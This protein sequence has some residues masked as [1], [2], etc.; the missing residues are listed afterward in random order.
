MSAA[1]TA[2][3]LDLIAYLLQH[4]FPVTRE[5]IFRHI[6]G[7]LDAPD[8]ASATE[9]ESARRQ[10]ERDKD[11]LRAL[12]IALETVD[13]PDAAGD[14]PAKG[15]RLPERG[16]YLPYI[17]LEPPGAAAAR[18][19]AGLRRIAV[20]P[21]E[22]RALD[23]AT[24]RVAELKVEPFSRAALS[25]RRKLEF[26]LPLNREVF[27]RALA[28]PLPDEGKNALEVVQRAVAERLA[29]TCEYYAIGRDERERREIEPCGL[30]FNWGRWYCVARAR[31]RDA[32]RVFRVDRM[33]NA[34]LQTGRGARFQLPAGFSIRGYVD[35]APWDL[36][37][38]PATTVRVRFAFPDS[39]R[40]QARGLGQVIEPM[41]DDAG[42]IIEFIVRDPHPFLRW[43]LTF[44]R[45]AEILSPDSLAA[46]LAALRRRVAARYTTT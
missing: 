16:F 3:W 36:T 6:R 22:L 18:P 25:A 27:E 33:R 2:R 41:L 14:E 12:G 43:L 17:E 35:R 29:V 30:F 39:R 31:D 45:Q 13:I 5:D 4:R 19:Y 7:Y 10:F 20:S 44:G 37:D 23:Q 28:S 26:D 9:Q 46:E 21:D 24:A 42:A 34:R 38:E 11:E 15:Y 8:T 40:V 1:K 32:L